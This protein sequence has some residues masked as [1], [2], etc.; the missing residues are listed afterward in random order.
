MILCV[1]FEPA[2]C[3]YLDTLCPYHS[4]HQEDIH[5]LDDWLALEQASISIEVL[6][7][8]FLDCN[9]MFWPEWALHL[10]VL[11]TAHENGSCK[12]WDLVTGSLIES[13]RIPPESQAIKKNPRGSPRFSQVAFTTSI[14]KSTGLE[15][16]TLIAAVI[17]GKQSQ[18]LTWAQKRNGQLGLQKEINA[19]KAPVTAMALSRDGE[20]SGLRIWRW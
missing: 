9:Y 4:D 17:V 10:Q 7:I 18:I 16:P 3:W 6:K 2:T 11:A 20:F 12:L 1:A 5:T 8:L 13:L 14:E 15:V 19:H